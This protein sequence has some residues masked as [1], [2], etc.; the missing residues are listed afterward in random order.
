MMNRL[1]HA[2]P[3]SRKRVK[4]TVRCCARLTLINIIVDFFKVNSL[5][6]FMKRYVKILML[7]SLF[8][9]LA[10]FSGYQGYLQSG[11]S[12]GELMDYAEKRLQGHTRLEA[13]FSPVFTELRLALDVP[14][15]MDRANLVVPPPPEPFDNIVNQVNSA[16]LLGE[17]DHLVRVGPDQA[18]KSIR[19]AARLAKDGDTVEI[20]AGNYHGDVATWSQR[21]LTIR[22]VGGNARIFA[23]GQSAEGKAIW[24]IRDGK[25]IVENID[26]IGT[27]VSDHNG[28][29]IRFEKGNL[30]I[31]NCLFYG[32]E[33]G[34]LATGGDA[35]LTIEGSE[36]AYNG[37]G[38]GQS[39]NLYVGAIKSLNV[40]GSYFH[41]ANVGH[42]LK[43]RAAYN[44]IAY[45]R[46]TDETGHA[47]YELEFPNG[48]IA[49]V[50]GNIIQQ[51]RFTENSTLISYG[52]E[53]YPWSD[54]RLYLSSNSL[55]ND[56][57]YGGSFLR[58][59]QG[60]QQV[61]SMNNQ[62]IGV[63]EYHT[64]DIL[65]TFND[66]HEDWDDFY[67]VHDGEHDVIFRSL[68]PG[69]AD[70]ID[71]VPQYEYLHPRQVRKLVTPPV[72]TGAIQMRLP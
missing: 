44:F 17:Y 52:A 49:Y 28:A 2:L 8:L 58:V 22:G 46:L 48:G 11:H 24:V 27:R 18:I 32:N 35:E 56:L 4:G 6:I 50:I 55:I 39:H 67:G 7:A 64:P 13:A 1:R 19:L 63:G 38:D 20:Q 41:H 3:L 31:R 54:N 15:Q 16:G 69:L 60:A 5:D 40:T 42:L 34:L 68:P 33:N 37:G 26:F 43:S 25:F 62:L 21:K 71:L 9:I 61:V 57:P 29:G 72:V 47:S 53:K 51:S 70:G 36:F 45:N 66:I 23:D 12:P 30:H 59:Y 10:L 65:T 14:S